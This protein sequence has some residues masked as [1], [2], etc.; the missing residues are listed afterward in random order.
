LLADH[1]PKHLLQIAVCIRHRN[2]AFADDGEGLARRPQRGIAPAGGRRLAL[3]ANPRSAAIVVLAVTV[4]ARDAQ[5]RPVLIR[6]DDRMHAIGLARA[7]EVLDRFS[8]AVW[9]VRC[10]HAKVTQLRRFFLISSHP[11]SRR[12]ISFSKPRSV[13]W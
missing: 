12:L 8:G 10:R 9:A 1:A 11:S 6:D 7:A 2:L 3:G 13:G 4:P 5:R